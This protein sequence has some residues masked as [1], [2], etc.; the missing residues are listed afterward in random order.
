MEEAESWVHFSEIDWSDEKFNRFN[1]DTRDFHCGYTFE[2]KLHK[3]I[4]TLENKRNKDN[5][6]CSKD[7]LI[8][9]ITRLHKDSGGDAEWRY[10]S[11][12]TQNSRFLHWNMKYLRIHRI[13]NSFII[14]N[15]EHQALNKNILMNAKINEELLNAH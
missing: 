12:M 6:F 14:C 13:D 9:I 11:L 4:K 3:D 8:Q 7:E 2:N 5:F 15:S 10:V 1:I